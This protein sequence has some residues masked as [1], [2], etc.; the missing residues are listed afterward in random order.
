MVASDAETGIIGDVKDLKR[1]KKFFGKNT[2]SL[3]SVRSFWA[4]AYDQLDQFYVQLLLIVA[5]ILLVLSFFEGGDVDANGEPVPNLKWVQSVSVYVAVL[6]ACLIQT[7]CD[8]G[9]EQQFLKLQDE[10]KNQTV[11]VLRGQYGTTQQ[12]LASKLVVGD[13]IMLEA[14]DRVPADC[15][16]IEEMDMF[17]DQSY[18]GVTS[19]KEHRMEKQVSYQDPYEDELKNPDP[20]LLT[21]SLVMAGS[22][23]ALVMCVGGRSLK[24]I[25]LGEGEER[26]AKLKL[27]HKETPLQKKLAVIS[28]IIG[29]YANVV[30]WSAFALFAIV[31]FLTY[32]FMSGV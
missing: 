15:L 4:I 10:I 24:E 23:K 25:E 18:Y 6:F 27:E 30:A 17:V 20:M 32:A 12:V 21:D 9:K 2:Q 16:L 22:G 14:G 13:V 1:R 28:Q 3:P 19:D 26:A 7:L 5:T 8:W 29:L 11:T 31:W